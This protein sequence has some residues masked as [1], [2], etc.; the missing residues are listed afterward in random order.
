VRHEVR[1]GAKRQ[2]ALLDAERKALQATA[3]AV[4]AETDRIVAAW[5]LRLLVGAAP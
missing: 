5:Q 4:A 3:G 2:L 1:V